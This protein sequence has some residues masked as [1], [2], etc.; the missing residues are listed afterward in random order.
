V[1]LRGTYNV[2]GGQHRIPRRA[3]QGDDTPNATNV[4][5]SDGGDLR[6][7]AA[8][9]T[10]DLLRAADTFIAPTRLLRDVRDEHVDDVGRGHEEVGW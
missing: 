8:S 9:I 6:N 5:H 7:A 10:H 1:H 2:S 3:F 4:H